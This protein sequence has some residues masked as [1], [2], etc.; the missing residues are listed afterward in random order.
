MTGL[1][2]GAGADRLDGA[3]VLTGYL[4]RDRIQG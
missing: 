3:R 1:E 2:G 4:T